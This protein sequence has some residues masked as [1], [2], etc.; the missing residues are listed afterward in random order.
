MLRL[1]VAATLVAGLAASASVACTTSATPVFH[2]TL[3]LRPA[4][5]R[6]DRKHGGLGTIKAKQWSLTPYDGSNGICVDQ[7]PIVITIGSGEEAWRLDPGMLK[8]AKNGKSWSYRAKGK[9]PVRSLRSLKIRLQD[10]GSYTIAFVLTGVDMSQLNSEDP[11]CQP[12]AFI[13]GDD[14]G[15]TGLNLTSPTF[16]SPRVTVPQD[17]CTPNSWPWV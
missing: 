9:Q 14:D 7:E 5:G 6:I 17:P 4:K 13:I 15:F 12:F 8:A 11:V 10:D 2:G 1:V 3:A 16:F